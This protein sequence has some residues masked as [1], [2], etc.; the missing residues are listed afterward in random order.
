VLGGTGRPAE[1]LAAHERARDIFERLVRDNPAVTQFQHGLASSHNSNGTM[2]GA[3]G[4]PAEALAAFEQARAIFERLA[5]DNPAVTQFERDLAISQNNIG[6]VLGDTGRPADALAAHEQA[7]DIQERLARDNHS[8]TQFQSDMAA[9]H[10]NIGRLFGGTDRPA[11][12]LAAYE[13]ARAV[14]ERLA[15]ENPAFA[16]FQRDLAES[17][18]SIGLLHRGSG[19]PAEALAAH[20][21]ARAIFE[22]LAREHPESLDHASSLGATLNN[23]AVIDLG[24]QHFAAAR[25]KLREAV[26]WQRKALAGNPK[27]PTY[28]ESLMMHLKNLTQ[29]AQGLGRSVEAVAAERELDELRSSDPRFAALDARLAV[30]LKGG[31]PK[32]N[33]ER[34]ALGQQAYDTRRFAT[35][36]KLW[37]EALGADPKLATDRQAQRSYNA[38]CAAALAAAGLGKDEPTPDDATKARLRRQV[39]VWLEGELAAWERLLEPGSPEVRAFIAQTLRHWQQDTDLAAVRDHGALG[40]LP[41]LERKDWQ[42]L[43]VKVDEMLSRAGAGGPP[44]PASETG[45]QPAD[46]FT[47]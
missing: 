5:R 13:R 44:T 45:E 34:L 42:A 35:A 39:H 9:S 25:D 23:I 15:R 17:H 29:A 31:A 1:A 37:A 8:V 24:A 38:A 10:N 3:T 28:R 11:E 47:R 2:L 46:P 14:F 40:E 22:R 20:E 6:L 18:G 41:E 7:L 32:D 30:I 26:M 4:R 19:R 21:R 33:A 12:A 16:G 27:N 36:A 43:W